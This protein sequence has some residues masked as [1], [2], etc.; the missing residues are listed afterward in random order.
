MKTIRV[1]QCEDSVE[2]IFTAVYVA[3]ASR[4]G[5]N[6]IR[7][8]A[9]MPQMAS[10]L[11]LFCEYIWVEKDSQLA[12]KVAE[13]IRSKISAKAYQMVVRAALSAEEM[14]ANTIYHF[15]VRGFAM[16]SKVTDH[17]TDSYVQDIFEM[18]RKVSNDANSYKEFLRF[19]EI[20]HNIL[21][22]KIEPKSNVVELI[23][24]HFADRLRAENF[25]IVD[26][27]RK[28]ATIHQAEQS[29]FLTNLT[30]EETKQLGELKESQENYSSL[31]KTFFDSIAIKERENY[32]LQRNHVALHY[33]KY[34]TEFQKRS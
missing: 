28:I 25:V 26:V 30:D 11:E 9:I 15:L 24:P 20:E 5:H 7:L 6:Y 33:R 14:K 3:W 16:G 21:L 29:W 27:P 2:G 12:D 8:Q 1:Y 32:A 10:N 22:A 17:L 18:N 13:S 23:T 4:Y 31:W 34:M 19:E